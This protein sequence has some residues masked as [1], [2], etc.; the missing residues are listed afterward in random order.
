MVS[1][2]ASE[3]HVLRSRY[4]QLKEKRDA[5]R[6]SDNTRDLYDE[7]GEDQSHQ[8]PEQETRSVTPVKTP[9][10]QYQDSVEL[11]RQDSQVIIFK[12]RLLYSVEI[13]SRAGSSPPPMKSQ[14]RS[15]SRV[16]RPSW[17]IR[18]T[19]PRWSSMWGASSM[20]YLSLIYKY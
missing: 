16:W 12:I 9:G 19:S 6:E 4:K 7:V 11:Y 2:M 20:R 18:R 3:V 15:M 13:H 1:S 14:W 5:L 10:L 8:K 17:T